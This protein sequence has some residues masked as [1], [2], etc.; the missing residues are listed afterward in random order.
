[1]TID[2]LAL[3]LAA[4]VALFAVVIIRLPELMQALGH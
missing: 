3:L 4:I 1:M 2:P